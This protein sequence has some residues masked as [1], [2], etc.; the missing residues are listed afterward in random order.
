DKAVRCDNAIAADS[1]N[2]GLTAA[3]PGGRPAAENLASGNGKLVFG[4]TEWNK[5]AANV[6]VSVTTRLVHLN[7]CVTLPPGQIAVGVGQASQVSEGGASIIRKRKPGQFLLVF[8]RAT[9]REKS[10]R[11]VPRFY[12]IRAGSCDRSLRL[13]IAPHP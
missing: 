11:I 9:S 4:D 5:D 6:E 8:S 7:T 3:E 2:D 12:N 13:P 1:G 10:S